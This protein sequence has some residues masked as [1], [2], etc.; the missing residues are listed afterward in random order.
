VGPALLT[1]LD[2]VTRNFRKTEPQLNAMPLSPREYIHRQVWFTPF[3]GEPVGDLI[4]GCGDDLFLF[5]SD[6]PHPEGGRDPIKRFEQSLAGAR[7]EALSKFYSE[8]FTAMM[9]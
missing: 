4:D 3:P 5:S 9:G 7:P 6:Y 8:N 1:R 2:M